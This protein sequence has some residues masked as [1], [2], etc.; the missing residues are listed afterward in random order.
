MGF[1]PTPGV[2]TAASVTRASVL[3]HPRWLFLIAGS[4]INIGLAAAGGLAPARVIALGVLGVAFVAFFSFAPA[5]RRQA[6]TFRGLL[7]S[8]LHTTLWAALSGGLASPFI[9]MLPAPVVLTWLT[10]GHGAGHESRNMLLVTIAAMSGLLALPNA[11]TGPMLERGFFETLV[12][13]N[14]LLSAFMMTAKI[15][16][17]MAGLAATTAS[18]NCVR[19]GVLDD[20]ATRRRGL[21][22]VG[23]KVAHELKNPLAAI[24]SLVQ[25]ERS[26]SGRDD[27]SERRL[28]VMASEVTRMEGILRDYLTFSRPF[29][30]LER[31]EID[32]ATVVDEV[33]AVLEGRADAAGIRLSKYGHGGVIFADG[34]RLKEALINL[35]ANAI[36]ATPPGGRVDVV[37]QVGDDASQVM[38]YDTGRGM[39]STVAARIGTPFFTTREDGTGLGVVIARAAAAEHGGTLEFA[40]RPM[41]G[42]VATIALPRAACAGQEVARG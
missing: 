16:L 37:Y 5:A 12:G 2:Y 42:T 28:E 13:F 17:L 39:S 26:R 35:T 30:E 8:L 9:V 36:E 41:G 32:L 14:L 6:V 38:I 4:A 27:R 33:V 25:L 11:W 20:A 19:R 23:T 31:A 1:A 7:L 34:R 15:K 40:S 24:K 29:D 3:P 18:L 22:A 10:Y 21:E